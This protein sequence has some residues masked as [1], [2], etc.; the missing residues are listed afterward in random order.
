MPGGAPAIPG[1]RNPGGILLDISFYFSRRQADWLTPEAYPEAFRRGN[2]VAYHPADQGHQVGIQEGVERT[3]W[4]EQPWHRGHLRRISSTPR[5]SPRDFARGS[6]AVEMDSPAPSPIPRP[7]ATP[8]PGPAVNPL[9]SAEIGGGPSTL[10]LTMVSPLRITKPRVRFCCVVGAGSPSFC[11]FFACTSGQS[12][13]LAC[14]NNPSAKS[15]DP[16]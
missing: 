16:P 6:R 10:T 12:Y 15:P 14:W 1:G 8:R 4:V 13:L 2:Q 7:A 3:P 11:C 9:S 5:Q